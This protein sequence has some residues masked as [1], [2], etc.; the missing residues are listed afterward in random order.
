MNPYIPITPNI[1]PSDII[2]IHYPRHP[3]AGGAPQRAALR[4][5]RCSARFCPCDARK[6]VRWPRCP[7]NGQRGIL[8][9]DPITDPPM[10]MS[11]LHP[12]GDPAYLEILFSHS[13]KPPP[14]PTRTVTSAACILAAAV[15]HILEAHLLLAVTHVPRS[16][17]VAVQ[18]LCAS[19][20][21]AA[22]VSSTRW[23]C[24]AFGLTLTPRF[25][26]ADGSSVDR[27]RNHN[28]PCSSIHFRREFTG[29]K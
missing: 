18:R 12:R 5:V 29:K 26:V 4:G 11:R 13:T 22:L 20:T 1:R 23:S 21:T 14:C 7:Q 27:Y 19:L 6:L 10:G 2:F 17:R 28:G 3:P 9:I 25:D 16:Q 8:R 24:L 15:V